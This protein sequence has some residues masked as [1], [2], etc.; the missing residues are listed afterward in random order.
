MFYFAYFLI[1]K[2]VIILARQARMFYNVEKSSACDICEGE[3]CAEK[4]APKAQPQV[5]QKQEVDPNQRGGAIFAS[6]KGSATTVCASS[7]SLFVAIFIRNL[8]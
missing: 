2:T 8:I 1:T 5:S 6:P 7:L 4:C 3:E